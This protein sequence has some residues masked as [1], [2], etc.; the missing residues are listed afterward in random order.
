MSS[1]FLSNA[2]QG[3]EL[4]YSYNPFLVSF[5]ILVAI[6][7][8]VLALQVAGLSRQT[9]RTHLRQF[10]LISGSL[11]L[12][13][14]I[15]SMH[16]IGMLAVQVGVHIHYDPLVT[17]ASIIPSIFAS[18][19]A[20]Q[21][22][23]NERIEILQLIVGGTLVGAG[24][25][26]MHYSGMM[27]MNTDAVILYE[28][29]TFAL[30]I[31]AAICLAIFALW[32][33]F[34][35]SN[36]FN[37]SNAQTSLLAGSIMG[38]AIT[39]MHYI[40][41]AASRILVEESHVHHAA[42]Y[43]EVSSLVLQ[44]GATT[45][46]LSLLVFV[47][48]LLLRYREVNEQLS[49]SESRIRAIVETAVDGIISID[50][51]GRILAMNGAAQRLF[52]WTL[53][54]VFDR[55]IN[56]LMPE[57]FHSEHDGYLDNFFKTGNPRIIGTGREV[58]AKRKDGSLVPI[59]LAVGKADI[60]GQHL[61][62]GFVSDIS[63]RITMEREICARE[64]QYR[65]LIGNIP[66]VAFRCEAQAPWKTLFI[67]D[68]I[69]TLSGWAPELFTQLQLNLEDITHPEDAVRVKLAIQHSLATGEP[70]TIEFRI[71]DRTQQERWVSQSACVVKDPDTQTAWIDGVIID[72]TETKKR[73]AEFEG[74][75]RS[76]G[77]SL[78]FVEFDL[79]GRVLDANENFSELIGY[80][81]QELQQ[82][83][84]S[85]LICS[86]DVNAFDAAGFWKALLKGEFQMGEYCLMGNKGRRIWMQATF[87]PILNGDGKP[88]KVVALGNDL[89]HRKA[90]ETD[91]F[92]AKN[93]AEQAANAKGLF[94]A[95]MSHEIRTPMNAILGFTDLLLDSELNDQQKR[96]LKTIAQ[97]A[98]SLLGLLNDI[99]DTAKL[100]RGALDLDINTFSLRD[101]THQVMQEQSANAQ[102]KS[103]QFHIDYP[104]HLR[105][106]VEG[107]VLRLKQILVNLVGNAVKFTEQGEVVLRVRERE[108][109]MVFKIVDSGIGIP[110][111]RL[112]HIFTPF[113]QADASMAR[114]FG[115]TGLGT[116]IARQLAELMNGSINAASIEGKG[117]T[118]TVDVPLPPSSAARLQQEP[119][120]IQLPPLSFLIADDVAENIELLEILLRR[121]GHRVVSATD[122]TQAFELFKLQ[123][124][125]VVLM[126]I[127][128]PVMDGLESTRMIRNWEQERNLPSTP[129]I[130]L[131]AS[132]LERDRKK[133]ADAG[134]NGFAS[135]PVSLRELYSEIASNLGMGELISAQECAPQTVQLIDWETAI[136][137]W[138][139][140]ETLIRS[141]KKYAND[142]KRALNEFPSLTE[143][144]LGQSIHRF[145]GT[146]ANLGLDQI[147]KIFEALEQQSIALD[148]GISQLHSQ[149]TDIA[150]TLFEQATSEETLD[151]P[152]P[153]VVEGVLAALLKGFRHGTIDDE[154]LTRVKDSIAR[155]S[156]Q[157]LQQAVDDFDLDAAADLVEAW[158]NAEASCE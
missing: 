155:D 11:A 154:L 36:Y 71:M 41:M 14:G 45:V 117:S 157:T 158:L 60:P 31:I 138:G 32:V 97:S 57:P 107:D 95:N 62:V 75:V 5:S 66:G 39:A 25:G 99:L 98:R 101:L 144:H 143:A 77:R 4:S 137:R 121:E 53:E 132:V 70:Y 156:F 38:I 82:L 51:R 1:F 116:T 148:T 73:N 135:K 54:E 90:M 140:R 12:G 20:L 46:T 33:K 103:I 49:T 129:V 18:W 29:Y 7:S 21:M 78:L 92:I 15:W 152:K 13:G 85:N 48:N 150:R 16:F 126:D 149:L 84:H 110:G 105:D 93:K 2:V 114:R 37:I 79:T 76:I 94:L 123:R 44:I 125:D 134:M 10:A 24:I 17:L 119:P 108:D 136:A 67:S 69:T 115:G 58:V 43:S 104:S 139:D 28:P 26:A 130:A 118:F 133:A 47:G 3:V 34:K 145:R 131:T 68:A 81:K 19:V 30:S 74:I 23:A 109:N 122:G 59:R 72:I 52:G 9:D 89:S 50:G 56:I 22:L 35:L 40:G 100:E 87:N 8:S 124:F 63:E 113:T 83:H 141:I 127:Q 142:L 112:A 6:I 65:T 102:K 64:T 61:Y 80:T 55:N 27:A 96:H 86:M 106:F 91:L 128:M 111:N 153:Q 151:Q 42:D 147:W 146:S 88:W 120:K